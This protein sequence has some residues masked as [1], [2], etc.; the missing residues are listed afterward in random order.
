MS[1]LLLCSNIERRVSIHDFSIVESDTSVSCCSP[2]REQEDFES[3]DG[4]PTDGYNRVV[5]SSFVNA[6]P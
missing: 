6:N 3:L 2:S 4:F 5:Y 1:A